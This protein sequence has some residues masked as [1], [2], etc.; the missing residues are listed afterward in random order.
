ME[1]QNKK[2]L[3]TLIVLVAIAAV[4]G[5]I[6]SVWKS[7]HP[8]GGK[9]LTPAQEQDILKSLEPSRPSP[10]ALTPTQKKALTTLGTTGTTT[11]QSSNSS[12]QEKSILD[13]L[14]N[15]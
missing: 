9:T 1:G 4:I 12:S 14:Q 5:V 15:K 11:K 13:S 10:A 7:R 2:T 8:A 6:Y 3:V